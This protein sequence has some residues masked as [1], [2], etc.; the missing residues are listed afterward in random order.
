[1]TFVSKLFHGLMPLEKDYRKTQ[2]GLHYSGR[3]CKGFKSLSQ[4]SLVG[5]EWFGLSKSE[6]TAAGFIQQG[7]LCDC[8]SLGE[9]SNCSRWCQSSAAACKI[10]FGFEDCDRAD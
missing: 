10:S 1:M 9:E 8:D 6:R 2:P 4:S 3:F 5:R 7:V